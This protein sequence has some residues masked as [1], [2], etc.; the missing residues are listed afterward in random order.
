MHRSLRLNVL[1]HVGESSVEAHIQI[2]YDPDSGAE[3]FAW[4]IP[5]QS[6]P[7]FEG[8]PQ[9]LFDAVL[10]ASVPSYGLQIQNDFCSSADDEVGG[11]ADGGA[12]TGLAGG[13]DG[14]NG[15]GDGEPEVVLNT[16]VGTLPRTA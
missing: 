9:L 1:F 6:I 15:E 8:G 4:V 11:A 2:Q 13:D 3:Q 7:E 5:V 14:D 10:N 16:T 12:E